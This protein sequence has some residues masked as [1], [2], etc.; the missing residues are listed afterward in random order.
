MEVQFSMERELTRFELP[1]A[2]Q[3]RLD[4]LLDRQD[5]GV[6]LGEDE[7]REAEGL[8]EM[9]EFLSLLRLRAERAASSAAS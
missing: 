7:R 5:R 1:A 6:P 9:A 2:V 4:A 8:V 3:K